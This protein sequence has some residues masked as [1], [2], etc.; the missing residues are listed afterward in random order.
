MTTDPDLVVVYW[1]DAEG[2]GA[3]ELT[4]DVMRCA[5]GRNRRDVGW[6]LRDDAEGVVIL[7]G[8]IDGGTHDRRLSVPRAYVRDVRRL[9]VRREAK[10]KEPQP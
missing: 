3:Q 6:L 4:E 10:A 8:L 5:I 7:G 1:L 2:S 9:A